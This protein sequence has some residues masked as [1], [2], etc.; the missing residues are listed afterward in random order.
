MLLAQ[1]QSDT[2]GIP[3][4]HGGSNGFGL[5]EWCDLDRFAAVVP[6]GWFVSPPTTPSFSSGAAWAVQEALKTKTVFALTAS[7]KRLVLD[8]KAPVDFPHVSTIF[9]SVLRLIQ[10]SGPGQMNMANLD[11]AEVN[12]ELLVSALRA[13][14]RWRAEV[15]GWGDAVSVARKALEMA[16]HK[17]IDLCLAGLE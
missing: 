10:T 3:V 15:I 7:W 6:V 11:A 4:F 12:G 17:D 16:N 1:Q 5:V 2:V 9:D 13:S 8:R 14:F